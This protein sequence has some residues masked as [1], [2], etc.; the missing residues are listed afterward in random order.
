M[1]T[2]YEISES[3]ADP[4]YVSEKLLQ[5]VR[6]PASYVWIWLHALMAWVHSTFPRKEAP[7][8]APVRTHWDPIY[9]YAISNWNRKERKEE[10]A[11][12]LDTWVCWIAAA[13]RLEEPYENRTVRSC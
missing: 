4:M 3:F 2:G 7:K 12:L 5:S 11:A 10:N 9:N 1:G 8:A 6:L 13:M